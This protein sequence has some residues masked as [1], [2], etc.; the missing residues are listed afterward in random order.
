[1]PED[2]QQAVGRGLDANLS[3]R[4]SQPLMTQLLVSLA[5]LLSP[6]CYSP[7]HQ[8]MEPACPAS[9]TQS[10]SALGSW[11]PEFRHQRPEKWLEE[12]HSLGWGTRRYSE[13][14]VT[15]AVQVGKLRPR[16]GVTYPKSHD[17]L[18]G[19]LPLS[20]ASLLFVLRVAQ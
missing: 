8:G 13:I 7:E 14:S 3:Q 4:A 16:D 19:L 1:M 20:P 10:W 11:A 2:T 6:T 5:G 9:K 18:H 15:V 17:K 12:D